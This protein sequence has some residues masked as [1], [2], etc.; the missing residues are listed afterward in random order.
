MSVG[1]Y[2]Y[3]VALAGDRFLNAVLGGD[4]EWSLSERMGQA[5]RED[6]CAGC[7]WICRALAL[8]DRRHCRRVYD[9]AKSHTGRLW[10]ARVAFGVG[11]TALVLL[12]LSLSGC[13][14]PWSMWTQTG[15]QPVCEDGEGRCKD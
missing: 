15:P 14:G 4:P 2:V 10:S 12:A 5:I 8:I 9:P 13:A 1:R 11:M 6:R 3:N 7:Y